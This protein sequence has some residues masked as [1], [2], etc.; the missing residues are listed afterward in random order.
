MPTAVP[1]NRANYPN[2]FEDQSNRK[3]T[4]LTTDGL[5]FFDGGTVPSGKFLAHF[6]GGSNGIMTALRYGVT[7][8]LELG[9]YL[10]YVFGNVD[11]SEQGIAAKT[12]FLN[13]GDGAPFTLSLAASLGIANQPVFNF[14]NNDATSF[15]NSGRDKSIPFLFG[16]QL[17]EQNGLYVATVSLPIQY[18][19]SRDTAV[20]V[21][22]T[23]GYIQRSGLAVAGVNVGG[24]LRVIGDVSLLGEVGANFAGDGNAFIN[25]RLADRIPWNLAVRW[26]PSKLFGFDFEDAL[27]RPS[28][29]LFVT[30]R[31]GA[32]TF[33]QLRV[34]EGNDPSVGV[35]V[36]VP[37]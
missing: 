13:Q 12:R 3:D 7:R 14:P 34:S 31:V 10:D 27:A 16:G 5:G 22:P 9:T 32:S 23:I 8:D 21:T 19:F 36:S 37:F 18:Q 26:Q 4:P 28:F 25:N 29:E 11:E 33:Q 2:N 24:S 6:Q 20:W 35:G 30:N 17:S 1:A 15:A